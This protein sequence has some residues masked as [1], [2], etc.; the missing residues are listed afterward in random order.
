MDSW[1]E[2]KVIPPI[3]SVEDIED[4]YLL[5]SMIAGFLVVLTG[6]AVIYHKIKK[7]GAPNQM[8][9]LT[10]IK[11]LFGEVAK[12]LNCLKI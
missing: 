8:T 12:P 4:V 2:W 1:R 3:L 10:K 7:S 9:L 11:E 5:G 6:D